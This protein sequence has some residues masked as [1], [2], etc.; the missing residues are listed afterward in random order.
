VFDDGVLVI[1]GD[2]NEIDFKSTSIS[3]FVEANNSK[4][5]KEHEEEDEENGEG[6]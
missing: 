2:P 4:D 1:Q 6:D 5:K 3:K